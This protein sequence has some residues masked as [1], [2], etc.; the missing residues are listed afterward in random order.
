MHIPQKINEL[1]SLAT[2]SRM[3]F[4][5]K[6]FKISLKKPYTTKCHSK[7]LKRTIILEKHRVLKT[8]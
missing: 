7:I 6:N 5:K 2:V 1:A 8:K 3:T 4:Q